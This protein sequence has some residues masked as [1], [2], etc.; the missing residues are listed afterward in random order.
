MC[1]KEWRRRGPYITCAKEWRR[2][3]LRQEAASRCIPLPGS[4]WAI[5][6]I[7]SPQKKPRPEEY[8]GQRPSCR[9]IAI[10]PFS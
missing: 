5:E 8:S 7:G 4:G 2:R 10:W 3:G 6:E 1:S 9:E